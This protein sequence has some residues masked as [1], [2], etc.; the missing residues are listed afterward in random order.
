MAEAS[1]NVRATPEECLIELLRL[2]ERLDLVIA[3]EAPAQL[4]SKRGFTHASTRLYQAPFDAALGGRNFVEARRILTT[5]VASLRKVI[6]RGLAL[7]ARRRRESSLLKT[8]A[9]AVCSVCGS[10]GPAVAGPTGAICRSCATDA[11]SLFTG[12]SQAGM[13]RKRRGRPTRG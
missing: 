13:S 10:R 5:A 11:S 8:R 12:S 7:R 6:A 9:R 3:A 2:S 4:S 1:E